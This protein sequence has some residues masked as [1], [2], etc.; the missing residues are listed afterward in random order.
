MPH[1]AKVMFEHPLLDELSMSQ[2]NT[3]DYCQYDLG[4]ELGAQLF[5]Y[6]LHR[7]FYL[8]SAPKEVCSL[9]KYPLT[10]HPCTRSVLSFTDPKENEI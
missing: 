8:K 1:G 4:V 10:Q 6:K 3:S 7:R 5:K 9:N 2:V